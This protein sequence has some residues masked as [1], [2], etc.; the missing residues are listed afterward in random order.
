MWTVYPHSPSSETWVYTLLWPKKYEQKRGVPSRWELEESAQNLPCFFPLVVVITEAWIKRESLSLWAPEWLWQAE[1]TT[2]SQW[3]RH[4]GKSTFLLRFRSCC[5]ITY[6]SW[7]IWE[8]SM[9]LQ[10]S[11]SR[12][13][14]LIIPAEK[15]MNM[16]RNCK[17]L[18]G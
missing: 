2:N 17:R 1:P 3:T 6:L 8:G 12:S 4:M 13:G 15:K 10:G 5:S 7:L 18:V 16:E 11:N 14:G 9:I